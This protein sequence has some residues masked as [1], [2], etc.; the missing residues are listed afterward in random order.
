MLCIR[1][2]L[3]KYESFV[4]ILLNDQT[5]IF[6][7]IQFSIS[8]LFALSLYVKQ[9]YLNHRLDAIS[10]YQFSPE[11]I[12]E[13]RQWRDTLHSPKLQHNWSHTIRLFNFI[14]R[15]LDWGALPLCRDVVG[16]FYNPSRLGWNGL[17]SYLGHLCVGRVLIFCR[18]V[19]GVFYNP[20]RLSWDGLVSYPGH[21]WVRRGLTPLQGGSR[22]ISQP[23]LTYG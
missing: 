23:Q 11:W 5:V 21:S 12:W 16:V 3:F 7:A 19:V 8:H 14:F 13:R 17:M 18:D 15:T 2:N 6:Q 10:Y 20:S 22:W 9:F 1:K 4:Y